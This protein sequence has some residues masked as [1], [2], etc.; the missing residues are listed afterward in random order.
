MPGPPPPPPP[1]PPGPPPPPSIK[2]DK[3]AG[4]KLGGGGT[5]RNDLLKSIQQGKALKKTV[6]N[7]RSSPVVGGT[8]PSNAQN[9]G[10]SGGIGQNEGSSFPNAEPPGLSGLGGLFAGGMPKLKS[11][12]SKGIK[13]GRIAGSGGSSGAA[14][15]GSGEKFSSG[16][17]NLA[18]G[19]GSRH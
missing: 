3:P 18:Q 14:G 5:D 1:P 16:I 11:A 7:D 12:G 17:N 15:G 2:V 8:K 6:T 9:S 4:K 19:S 10:Q 13:T